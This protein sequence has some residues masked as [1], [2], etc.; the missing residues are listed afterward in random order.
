MN[1]NME[2]LTSSFRFFF[3]YRRYTRGVP[4][5]YFQCVCLWKQLTPQILTTLIL[6]NWLCVKAKKN[7]GLRKVM[8]VLVC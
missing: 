7:Q 6:L 3:F 1:S 8:N 4:V 2:T 5:F